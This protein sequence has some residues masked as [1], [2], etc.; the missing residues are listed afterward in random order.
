[1]LSRFKSIKSKNSC[2]YSSSSRCTSPKGVDPICKLGCTED[3]SK[4]G[5]SDNITSSQPQGKKVNS[6]VRNRVLCGYMSGLTFYGIGLFCVASSEVVHMTMSYAIPSLLLPVYFGVAMTSLIY[7]PLPFKK[8][9][10]S[11]LFHNIL[12]FILL[13][14][15]TLNFLIIFKTIIIENDI[16]RLKKIGETTNSSI[17]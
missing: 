7:D 11:V 16:K 15:I 6:I 12:V 13:C 4:S 9:Y 8:S 17:E 5:S 14:M 10:T 3:L 1:M 2:L